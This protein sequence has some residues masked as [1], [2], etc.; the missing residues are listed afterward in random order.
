MES[1]GFA[2]ASGFRASSKQ[3]ARGGFIGYTYTAYNDFV[4]KGAV[5]I[6][7]FPRTQGYRG[8]VA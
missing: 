5:N 3:V 8:P 1:G 7:G 2:S 6:D 4:Q